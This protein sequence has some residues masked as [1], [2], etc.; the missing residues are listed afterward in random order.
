[1]TEMTETKTA[2]I[3]GRYLAVWSEADP[4]ARRAAIAEVWAP[5]GAEFTEGTQFRGHEEL[6]A[7][8]THAY[9]EFVGSGRYAVTHASDV[10]RHDDIVTLTI[11]LSDPDGEVA[12]A[13]RV[14]L[15]LDQ[16]GR[17][18]QDYQ[19]TVQPLAA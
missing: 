12:W 13:A 3:A 2:A 16:D 18:R 1:M 19:L 5:D 6:H 17:V 10:T 8:I 11:Q 4:A 7:R 14:F 15:L 9:Q